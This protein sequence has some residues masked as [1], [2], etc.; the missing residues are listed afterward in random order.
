[1]SEQIIL[2]KTI[3]TDETLAIGQRNKEVQLFEGAWYFD[4]DA[5]D[6]THLAISNRTFTCSYKGICYW[7]DLILPNHPP[8]KNVG[9]T[10][11]STSDGYEF[12]QDKIGLY[13]GRREATYQEMIP[14]PA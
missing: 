3:Q 7:I 10:Y 2:I 11:F 14:I 12:I 1:M 9:F 4:R 8:V 13:Y 5:V 6:M